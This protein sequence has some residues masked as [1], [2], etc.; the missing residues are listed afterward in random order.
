MD[1]IPPPI[2]WVM[3]PHRI[4]QREV[5][6]WANS[7]N[8]RSPTGEDIS[9]LIADLAKAID[10]DRGV[11][12]PKLVCSLCLGTGAVPTSNPSAEEV[13]YTPCICRLA[14]I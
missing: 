1:E 7:L 9:R 4:V 11:A 12:H 2:V 14:N 8:G 6:D 10:T 5:I 13:F 3:P